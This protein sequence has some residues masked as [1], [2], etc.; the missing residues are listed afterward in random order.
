M[1]EPKLELKTSLDDPH[2]RIGADAVNGAVVAASLDQAEAPADLLRESS[3]V[4]Y[5]DSE[6]EISA[7]F[8]IALRIMGLKQSQ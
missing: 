2:E 4:V 7:G 5:C 8:V 3:H 1:D 6:E